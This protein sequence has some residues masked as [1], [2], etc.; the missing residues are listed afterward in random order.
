MYAQKMLL[1]IILGLLAAGGTAMASEVH[2]YQH[3]GNLVVRHAGLPLQT[4]YR[5]GTAFRTEDNRMDFRYTFQATRSESNALKDASIYGTWNEEQQQFDVTEV[6]LVDSERIPAEGRCE[7]QR[8]GSPL[9]N[10]FQLQSLACQVEFSAN[11][12]M[13]LKAVIN[14]TTQ[15]SSTSITAH[16]E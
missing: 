9:T 2:E 10:D 15:S 7:L 8:T 1:G 5:F 11:D 14:S 12:V 13:V 3:N 6:S 4:H 16:A